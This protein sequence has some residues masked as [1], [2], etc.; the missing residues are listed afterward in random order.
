MAINT[1]KDAVLET[2]WLAVAEVLSRLFPDHSEY[3][4]SYQLAYSELMQTEPTATDLQINIGRYDPNSVLHFYV[5]GFYGDCPKGYCIK[6]IPWSDWLGIPLNAEIR[7]QFNTAETL[8]I[9]LNDMCWA[10]FSAVGVARFINEF[11]F[12]EHCLKA[13]FDH[14]AAIE[15]SE[16]N[17][18]KRKQR[19][20]EFNEVLDLYGID[21]DVFLDD[22]SDQYRRARFQLDV[23]IYCLGETETDYSVY[24]DKVKA[25]KEDFRQRWV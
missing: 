7:A 9:C 16:S 14:E 25:L 12:H 2:E 24:C 8:A 5:V 1:L 15:A 10:G 3:M 22:G 23:E 20:N 4:A 21:D 17:L 11:I 6:F 13:V 19:S 18:I